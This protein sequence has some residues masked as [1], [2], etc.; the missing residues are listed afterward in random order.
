[1][2]TRVIRNIETENNMINMIYN[3]SITIGFM[4]LFLLTRHLHFFPSLLLGIF[5]LEARSKKRMVRQSK[6][7]RGNSGDP[8]AE[9]ATSS[10]HGAGGAS[11]SENVGGDANAHGGAT[12]ASG[13]AARKGDCSGEGAG[14]GAGGDSRN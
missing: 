5:E 10:E 3:Y 8:V 7:R 2:S 9:D 11:P 1:M 12:H 6:R 14:M 4:R 13:A